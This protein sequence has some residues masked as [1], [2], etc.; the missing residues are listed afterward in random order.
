[1]LEASE[2]ARNEI[3]DY[4][5]SSFEKVTKLTNLP[6]ESHTQPHE[7][8]IDT[9]IFLTHLCDVEDILQL[10]ITKVS[11]ERDRPLSD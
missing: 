3:L 10:R 1:M 11:S 9:S 4:R 8:V 7:H 6:S 2:L 5:Q